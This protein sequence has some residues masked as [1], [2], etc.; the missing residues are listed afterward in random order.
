MSV[1]LGKG[2]DWAY[3]RDNV[4]LNNSGERDQFEV[5]GEIEL[6]GEG[7]VS[8]CPM[9]RRRG[10]CQRTE[11]TRSAREMVCCARDMVGGSWVGAGIETG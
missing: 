5:E 9:T 7:L 3:H 1:R 6:L 8:R 2:R 10:R 11:L 4:L